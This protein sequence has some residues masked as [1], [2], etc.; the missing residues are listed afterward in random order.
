MRYVWI[1]SGCVGAGKS[2]ALQALIDDPPSTLNG[3]QCTIRVFKEDQNKWLY[4]LDECRRFPDDKHLRFML[5]AEVMSHYQRTTT[6]IAKSPRNTSVDIHVF[7][8]RSPRDVLVLFVEPFKQF[9]EPAAYDALV[10]YIGEYEKSPVWQGAR[11]ICI[12]TSPQTCMVRIKRRARVAES[13]LQLRYIEDQHVLSE[14][15]LRRAAKVPSSDDHPPT[16]VANGILDAV[17]TILAQ[18]SRVKK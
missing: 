18:D 16:R 9:F 3:R 4:W 7:V 1:I 6:K 12:D 13:A 14:K 15:S 5:Q 17:K 2:A 10:N 8:E 11:R